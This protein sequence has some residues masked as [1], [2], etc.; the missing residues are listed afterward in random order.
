VAKYNEPEDEDAV[1]WTKFDF[2]RGPF[3]VASLPSFYADDMAS[4]YV[5]HLVEKIDLRR[6]D[7]IDS[8]VFLMAVMILTE[9]SRSNDA[10]PTRGDDCRT[11]RVALDRL[12][13]A[14]KATTGL[15]RP[16]DGKEAA[17]RADEQLRDWPLN[18][19]V[20]LLLR[21][22]RE[23]KRRRRLG[24][25]V[26]TAGVLADILRSA[27][28]E[29]RWRPPYGEAAIWANRIVA[30]HRKDVDAAYG[31]QRLRKTTGL[32]R[33]AKHPAKKRLKRGPVIR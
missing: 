15:R 7:E 24:E 31:V 21:A 16:I 9:A 23:T 6:W 27:N 29:A 32:S 17:R 20:N 1:P 25:A 28:K 3:R 10:N 12:F 19:E 13:R 4:L 14:I 11:A 33:R 22:I 26:E 30:R 18:L 2:A 5:P 8:D